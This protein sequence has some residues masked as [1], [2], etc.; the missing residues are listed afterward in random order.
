M[1]VTES[2]AKTPAKTSKKVVKPAESAALKAALEAAQIEMVPLSALVKSPLN[3]RTIPYPPESVREMADSILA[4]G[5]IQNLVVH[6]LPDGLSGVA[7]GGRRLAALQLLQR[8]QRIDAGHQVIVKRVSDELAVVASMV[9]NNNRVAMH[10]AEQISGFRTLSEQG[11]TPAQI[12]DQLGYSSRHVQRMLKL[13]SLAPELIALLAENTLDV[14]QCQA[15]SL[16]SDPARQVEIYQRVKAQHSYAPAHM[17][18]RAITDTEISVRDARFMFV[19]REA[20]EAAGGEVREDLFSAQEGDGTADGVLVGRL[21]QEKLESAALAVE[22]QEG[23]SWSL[24]REGAVRNYGDDREH[25]LVLPEPEGELS[26]DEQRRLDELYA[27]QEAT[28]T[29]EDEAAIQVLIDEIEE[30]ASIRAWTPEQKAA[31]GVVEIGR[32]HV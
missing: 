28:A 16:E 12:G 18:K 10:P 22:M 25:Y 24:A 8:E 20:Y 5:L 32:A 31:C 26:A 23:W 15:L 30:A 2:K 6:T 1:S 29:Y 19:G 13:A 7:A 17:L 21:V 27:T 14:E 9:E 4:V 3:V 11:K